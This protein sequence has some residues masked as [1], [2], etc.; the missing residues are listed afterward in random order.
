MDE[1]PPAPVST[2]SDAPYQERMGRHIRILQRLAEMGMNAAEAIDREVTADEPDA[3]AFGGD[4]ALAHSRVAASV[5]KVITLEARLDDERIRH[6][7]GKATAAQMRA[8][9][10]RTRKEQRRTYLR[11]TIEQLAEEHEPRDKQDVLQ[12][13]AKQ[14]GTPEMA[15]KLE[16]D[17]PAVELATSIY[18][19]L[20][21]AINTRRRT[22][23][24]SD[25][26]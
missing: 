10:D 26:P 8:V 12:E 2:V 16:S 11:Q 18:L 24:G 22:A 3:S 13:F 23:S 6:E 7:E 15:A 17:L 9:Y 1:I 19:G 5:V 20:L 21:A 4:L 25:P 14:V